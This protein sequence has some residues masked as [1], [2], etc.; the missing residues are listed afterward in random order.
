MGN[1]SI[2]VINSVKCVLCVFQMEF[3]EMR[4]VMFR[5]FWNSWHILF[6]TNI[7]NTNSVETTFAIEYSSMAHLF[8]YLILCPFLLFSLFNFYNN[9]CFNWNSLWL[10]Y[11]LQN[12]L[13]YKLNEVQFYSF[14]RAYYFLFAETRCC[15]RVDP[16]FF[17]YF[18]YTIFNLWN[19]IR[20]LESTMKL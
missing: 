8:K 12:T 10:W 16:H 18:H 5:W 4:N 19:N 7:R 1:S 14:L 15:Y 13:I 6:L 17:I 3:D 20:T 9:F 11:T 2:Y